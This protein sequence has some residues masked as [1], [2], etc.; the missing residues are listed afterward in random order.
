M[1]WNELVEASST[2]LWHALEPKHAVSIL[3][4]NKIKARTGQRYWPDGLR[5]SDDDPKYTESFWMNGV[6]TTRDPLYA[7]KWNHV[8]LEFDRRA[9]AN[10]YKIIPYHWGYSIPGNSIPKREREEF[11][12]LNYAEWTEKDMRA[13]WEEYEGN[14]FSNYVDF[15]HKP[16]KGKTHLE[17]LSKYLKNVFITADAFMGKIEPDNMPSDLKQIMQHPKYA[18]ILL[19]A[20]MIKSAKKY[21][22]KYAST[23][24][25]LYDT[26]AKY[27]PN[28]AVIPNNFIKHT[29]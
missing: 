29:K 16:G 12:A 13:Q 15:M 21:K 27:T 9:L 2:S 25:Q 20:D 4:D 7:A 28:Q 24:E 18:G 26:Q 1:R 8:V 23:L 14:N 3:S 6:S 5:R 11:I 19:S 17:P 22:G 10:D